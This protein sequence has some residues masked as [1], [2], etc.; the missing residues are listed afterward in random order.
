MCSVHCTLALVAARCLSV[1][2]NNCCLGGV[3]QGTEANKRIC[4]PRPNNGAGD[5]VLVGNGFIII[6]ATVFAGEQQ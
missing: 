6:K 4:G 3:L 5:K 1:E 2:R